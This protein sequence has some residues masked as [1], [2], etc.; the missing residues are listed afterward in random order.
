MSA[1]YQITISW[2]EEDEAFVARVPALPGCISHGETYKD[3]L[4]NIQ[5]AIEGF[6]AS[7]AAHGDTIPEP[8]MAADEIRRFA[9]VLNTSALAKR[10]GINRYTLASKLR[11]GTRFTEEEAKK[12]RQA[13]AL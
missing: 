12:I 10:A 13:L 6:L 8:D 1:K 9:P 2:S 7:M 4:E 5:D 11:R 3:A